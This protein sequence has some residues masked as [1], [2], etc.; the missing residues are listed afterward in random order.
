MLGVA[1]LIIDNDRILLIER[2]KEPMKGYWSLP[3]GLVEVG[4]RLE[5][6]L[7]RE[8][9]EETGLEIEIL[10][11][12]E[13]FER[14]TPGAEGRTEYHFVL[15]D[16]LCRPAGG[17]MA[18]AD[19]ASRAEWFAESEIEGLRI[20]PDTPRVIAKAFRMLEARR[21]AVPETPGSVASAAA[22]P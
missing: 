12:V 18:A 13:V 9:R 8:I 7:R 17:T 4:E 2:G 11:L 20:T 5:F 19:D 15:M 1:G 22:S 10:D 3:G 14:I 21:P 6:A 16:Y